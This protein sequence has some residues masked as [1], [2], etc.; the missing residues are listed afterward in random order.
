MATSAIALGKVRVAHNKGLP[1]PAQSLLDASGEN[2]CDAG[3]MFPAPGSRAG[4]LLPFGGHKGF[5][6][7]MVCELLG[8][9]LTGG[10]TTRPG[11]FDMKHAIWNNMLTIVFDPARLGEPS[12]FAAEAG[13]FIDWVKSARLRHGGDGILMP[14]EPERATR[15]ARALL[16]P[17]DEATLSQ[18]DEASRK[19]HDKC[20]RSPGPVSSL[21][22]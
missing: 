2:S 5:G 16:I 6:L 7:A 17:V 15:A 22:V 3:V 9:A 19:I 1:V 11:N 14:G 8:G 18:M 12:G 4:A 10:H 21:A 20:G 13:Q